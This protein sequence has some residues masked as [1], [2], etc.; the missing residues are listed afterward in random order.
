MVIVQNVRVVQHVIQ[1]HVGDATVKSFLIDLFKRT[2]YVSLGE[3][4]AYS[5]VETRKVVGFSVFL[6][7]LFVN[8]WIIAS[9]D[10]VSTARVDNLHRELKGSP[11]MKRDLCVTLAH[12]SIYAH[13]SVG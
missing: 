1:V 10:T 9:N 12:L 11:R 7:H 3:L 5:L 8:P 6:E 4:A 13:L 2:A